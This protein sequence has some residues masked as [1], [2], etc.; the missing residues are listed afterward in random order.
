MIDICCNL[1]HPVLNKQLP[2]LL[3]RAQRAGVQTMV[4]TGASV[5]DS[6]DALALAQRY[7]DCL[8]ATVGV[9]PHHAKHWDDTSYQTLQTLAAQDKIV[10]IG[11]TGLDYNRNFSSVAEQQFAFRQQIELAIETRLPLFTHQR[12]AHDDFIKILKPLR[13]QLGRVVVHCFTSERATLADYLELDFYIGVTG[14]ICDERRAAALRAAVTEIPADRL[15]L[16]TDAPYLLPRDLPKSLKAKHNE[17]AFLAHIAQDIARRR[18][19][20]Y[21]G[22]CQ[23]T[24]ANTCRFY[25]EA[26]MCGQTVSD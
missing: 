16:E 23:Q 7:P 2:N 3:E 18:S 19:V 15:M 24:I 9:H 6:H 25:G 14:W 8:C 11:E 12:D 10:A 5:E 4:V 17:P 13:Q 20:E 22:L 1:T 21:A 26:I